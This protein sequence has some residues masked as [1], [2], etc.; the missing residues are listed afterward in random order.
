METMFYIVS[1][2]RIAAF[3]GAIYLIGELTSSK[4]L[5]KDKA[6]LH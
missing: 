2:W 4:K 5:K 6:M 3:W 1:I